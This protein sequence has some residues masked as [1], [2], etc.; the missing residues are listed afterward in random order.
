MKLGDFRLLTDENIDPDVVDWLIR[1][2]FD[3]LD[4][5]RA[6]LQGTADVD[7]LKRATKESRV[8]ITHDSDFG[9]L[10]ILQ[11]DPQYTIETLK[12]VLQLNPEVTHP[13]ILVAKRIGPN[14][15]I[16]LREI[17]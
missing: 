1:E 15:I 9:T 6:G 7:L 17:E 4:V 13:F 14:V 12:S 10:A 5:C 8:V 11:G 2:G 16:R 3:V